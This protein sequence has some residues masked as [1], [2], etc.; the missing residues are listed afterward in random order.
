VQ[1]YGAGKTKHSLQKDT[2]LIKQKYVT[3]ETAAQNITN[4]LKS[5]NKK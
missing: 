3:Q 2:N 4:Q 1:E 5:S